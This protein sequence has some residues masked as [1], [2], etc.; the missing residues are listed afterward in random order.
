MFSPSPPPSEKERRYKYSPFPQFKQKSPPLSKNPRVKIL[1]VEKTRDALIKNLERTNRKDIDCGTN[2]QLTLMLVKDKD[3]RDYLRAFM[4]VTA[5]VRDARAPLPPANVIT[6]FVREVA[7]VLRE[8]SGAAD[9]VNIV[10]LSDSA[11]LVSAMKKEERV[12]F[13]I[14]KTGHAFWSIIHKIQNYPAYIGIAAGPAP[15]IKAI[16]LEW[17]IPF[18]FSNKEVRFMFVLVDRDYS[19]DNLWKNL[20]NIYHFNTTMRISEIEEYKCI[21]IFV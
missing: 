16:E 5:F 9:V 11:E 8:E 1:G 4:P 13:S 12:R 14:V 18:I 6:E 17:F 19:V 15:Q 10:N 3:T 2:R 21:A 7:F 20:T